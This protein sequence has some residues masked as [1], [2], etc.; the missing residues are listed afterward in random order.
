MAV[1]TL[2][3]THLK[4]LDTMVDKWTKRWAGIPR[5][6][7]NAMIH[8]KEGLDIPSISETYIEAH[9]TSHARTRGY[10]Y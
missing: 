2:P 6:A 10:D 9:N 4:K 1:H 8:M 5:N 3:V 7:T